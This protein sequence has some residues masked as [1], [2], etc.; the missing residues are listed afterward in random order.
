MNP[1]TPKHT[2]PTLTEPIEP[3]IPA[4]DD[5]LERYQIRYQRYIAQRK[6]YDTLKQFRSTIQGTVE[7]TTVLPYTFGCDTAYEMMVKLKARFAPTDLSRE[8]ET[9]L[10]YKK[11]QKPPKAKDVET[12]L[13]EWE[14]VYTRA[15]KLSL[16]DVA[17]NRAVTDFI[18]ATKDLHS[19]FQI[20]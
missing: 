18:E 6:R 10:K 2:L 4:S 19:P 9:I 11:L 16:P 12:W 8:K 13:Q 20:Y 17:N 15:S 1:E 3:D 5:G 14:T 7:L